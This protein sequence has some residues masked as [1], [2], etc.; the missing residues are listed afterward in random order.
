MDEE[1]PRFSID[2]RLPN[3]AIITCNE[4]LPLRILV[5]RLNEGSEMIFLQMIQI[6]LIGYTKVRAHE[7]TRTESGSWVIK[8]ASNMKMPLGK[9]ED[10]GMREFKVDSQLWAST[11]LPNTVA[12]SF[13]TCN[14]SR[15]YELE[16]K[17]GLAHG[18][19]G[20]SKVCHSVLSSPSVSNRG[21]YDSTSWRSLAIFSWR[22]FRALV[23]SQSFTAR[24]TMTTKWIAKT[25]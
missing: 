20:K 4:P 9:P 18:I 22:L 21:V 2:A 7:L 12:P 14:I 1:P 3:P 15:A 16:V 10:T 23:E 11:P 17:V 6:D 24:T 8:S 13:D 19:Y 25:N 5:K